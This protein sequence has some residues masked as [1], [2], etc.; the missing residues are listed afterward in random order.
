MDRFRG[1]DEVVAAALRGAPLA[2]KAQLELA[3]RPGPLTGA[4]AR[5]AERIRVRVLTWDPVGWTDDADRGPWVVV[6][7]SGSAYAITVFT[8]AWSL[9]AP[10][11]GTVA[12]QLTSLV[13]SIIRVG[14][15]NEA[16]LIAGGWASLEEQ[17]LVPELLGVLRFDGDLAPLDFTLTRNW[18]PI[19]E[20]TV[21]AIVTAAGFGP[22]HIDLSPKALSRTPIP[23]PDCAACAGGR[24]SVPF[25]L[26]LARPLLCGHHRAEALAQ[27]A[28]VITQAEK[29]NPDSW[30]AFCHA[31]ADL[32]PELHIPYPLRN[33][34]LDAEAG[35]VFG[36][37]RE[38]VLHDQAAVLLDYCVWVETP[39]RHEAA[40]WDV[41]WRPFDGPSS[42]DG[43]FDQ[44]AHQVAY[45]LGAAKDF[46][47]AA[48]VVDA[49]TPILPGSAANLHG[50]LATQLAEA[51]RPDE[52]RARIER[53]LKDPSADLLTEIYAGEVDE[54]TGDSAAA[55]ARYRSALRRA[56]KQADALYEH[57]VLCHLVEL[58]EDDEGRAGDVIM[59]KRDVDRAHARATGAA[60]VPVDVSRKVGRNEQC[61]CGSGRKFKRCHG[62]AS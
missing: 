59:L 56:R 60:P 6:A 7:G 39:Q 11:L 21:A 51:D 2:D 36:E 22:V 41:G 40:M 3:V 15:F 19:D 10:I 42:S 33:R 44:F 54:A 23:S 52:A 48:Q 8:G 50:E 24:Y 37:K 5:V 47:L 18:W 4:H 28:R 34:L 1:L 30:T 29:A 14:A 49:L 27:M 58:L 53:A 46:T 57:D 17:G 61:P 31:A 12:G 32:L 43:H 45:S 35:L 55:E 62:G 38:D 20:P 25:E 26:D 13:D 16:S 9:D